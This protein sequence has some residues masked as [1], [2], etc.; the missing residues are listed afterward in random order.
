MEETQVSKDVVV[1]IARLLLFL[2]VLEYCLG[3]EC[4]AAESQ[5]SHEKGMSKFFCT[6]LKISDN[7]FLYK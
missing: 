7:M 5:C 3:K 4:F 2:N 1:Y 6:Y